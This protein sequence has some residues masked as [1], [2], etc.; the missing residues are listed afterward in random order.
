MPKRKNQRRRRLRRRKEQVRK[1]MM[2]TKVVRHVEIMVPPQE[3]AVA[4][5]ATIT[6]AGRG[7]SSIRMET[8][9]PRAS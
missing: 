4:E 7:S 1:K 3:A 2:P 6:K 9:N 8:P 5:E